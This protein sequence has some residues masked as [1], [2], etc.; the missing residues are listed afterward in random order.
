[1]FQVFFNKNLHNRIA[2][3]IPIELA[4][5]SRQSALLL[6]LKTAWM[7]SVPIPYVNVI[8]LEISIG[9]RLNLFFCL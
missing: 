5:T 1:M 9:K 8:M 3:I 7:I 4:M 6:K 2:I